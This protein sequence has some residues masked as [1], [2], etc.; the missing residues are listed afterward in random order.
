[1]PVDSRVQRTIRRAFAVI[2]VMFVISWANALTFAYP[3]G[4]LQENRGSDEG[5]P[6]KAREAVDETSSKVPHSDGAVASD[7][8]RSSN[9]DS[10]ESGSKSGPNPAPAAGSNNE[11]RIGALEQKLSQMQKIIE[12]QQRTI[13]LLAGAPGVK[14]VAATN[15]ETAA[16]SPS[17]A[18]SIERAT[19]P[20]S[21]K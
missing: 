19:P 8:N 4:C 16:A 9:K 2:A 10:K 3:G 7:P 12:Q 14:P 13:E 18:S 5:G 1:M 15:A 11:D 20:D 21:Q 17:S 6:A